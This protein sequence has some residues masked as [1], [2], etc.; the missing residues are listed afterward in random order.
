[1]PSFTHISYKTHL[2]SSSVNFNHITLSLIWMERKY[3]WN[4]YITLRKETKPNP[5]LAS[6]QV[7]QASWPWALTHPIEP[8]KKIPEKVQEFRQTQP[9]GIQWGKEGTPS[10]PECRE[11]CSRL[12][13]QSFQIVPAKSFFNAN[14]ARIA[15]AVPSYNKFQGKSLKLILKVLKWQ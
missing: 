7:L 14:I 1:M 8:W 10:P 12:Q 6:T 15:N 5:K 9:P 11:T 4:I 3:N 13:N 2:I